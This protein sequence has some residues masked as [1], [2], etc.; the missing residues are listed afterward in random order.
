MLEPGRPAQG[1]HEATGAG[2]MCPRINAGVAT[3]NPIA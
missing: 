2:D 3:G 1:S